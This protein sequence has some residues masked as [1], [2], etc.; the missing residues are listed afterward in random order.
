MSYYDEIKA[1]RDGWRELQFHGTRANSCM[2]CGSLPAF[3]CHEMVRRSA[4]PRRWGRRANYLA[5]CRRCHEGPVV[6]MPLSMQLAHKL[7][8]DPD[9]F[10]LAIIS[11]IVG[12][13]VLLR[14]VVAQLKFI[15]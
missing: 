2:I 3:D 9:N 4:A 10:D 5:V 7:L 6:N 8:H 1:D 13:P 15:M 12:R 14:D 11:E